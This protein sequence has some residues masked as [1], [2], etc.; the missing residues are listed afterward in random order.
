MQSRLNGF[1]TEMCTDLAYYH[2]AINVAV[3]S[4][5][6]VAGVGVGPKSL[7]VSYYDTIITFP[8]F[9]NEDLSPLQ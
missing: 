8:L 9:E 2:C 7:L 5:H 4:N 3:D 6:L 1:G